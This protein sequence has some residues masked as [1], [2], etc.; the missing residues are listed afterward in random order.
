MKDFPACGLFLSSQSPQGD[1]SP[2]R[3]NDGKTLMQSVH[4]SI[5]GVSYEP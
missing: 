1:E 3:A 4:V 2:E 5:Y